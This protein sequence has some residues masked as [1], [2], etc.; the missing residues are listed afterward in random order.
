MANDKTLTDLPTLLQ[1]NDFRD[2]LL[3]GVEKKKREKVEYGT[4]LETW[5]QYKRVA[6]TDQ[7]INWVE[8]IL[9]RVTPMLSDPR[10]RPIL[11]KPVGDLKLREVIQQKKIF[12]LRIPQGQLNQN[13]DLLGSLVV[14]GVKQA[15]LSL[16]ME[17]SKQNPVALYL[18]NF[19]SFI[20]KET[21]EAITQETRKF[22]IGIVGATKTLQHLPDEYR[23]QVDHQYGLLDLLLSG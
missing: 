17:S 11:T 18:D 8:P 13:A 20:E 2:L 23:N 10:I 16:S 21:V 15:A 1:D 4:L 12:F 9:N 22:Q 7:W 5:S 6:R 19:D 3:D 14:T